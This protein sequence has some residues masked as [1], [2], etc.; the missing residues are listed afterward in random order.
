M[1]GV[2]LAIFNAV[3]GMAM[4]YIYNKFEQKP[5]NYDARLD[6]KVDD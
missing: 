1:V 5:E 3:G 2:M 6:I 4:A